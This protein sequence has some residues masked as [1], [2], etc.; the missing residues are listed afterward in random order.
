V[1]G[2]FDDEAATVPSRPPSEHAWPIA[3]NIIDQDSTAATPNRKWVVD[4]SYVWTRDRWPYL[5]VVIDLLSR[6]VIGWVVGERRHRDLALAALRKALV[7]RRP[8]KGL[9]HHSDRGSRYCS[10]D[11]HAELRRDGIRISVSG[12]GDYYVSEASLH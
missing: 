2:E 7:M 10:V 9:I 6:R 12:K 11:Y 3:P 5:P 4:I 1:Q 8:S